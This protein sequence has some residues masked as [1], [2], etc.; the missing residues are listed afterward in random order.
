LKLHPLL[1]WALILF[2]VVVSMWGMAVFVFPEEN[3]VEV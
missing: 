2:F 3:V 1:L